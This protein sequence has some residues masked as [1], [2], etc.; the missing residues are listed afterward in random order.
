LERR[1]RF[2]VVSP[3]VLD[4]VGQE[5]LEYA[6]R[7]LALNPDTSSLDLVRLGAFYLGVD[8]VE[9][10]LELTEAGL[11]SLDA[12]PAFAANVY[13]ATGQTERA[14]EIVSVRN[15]TS[16]ISGGGADRPN[17]LIPYGGAERIRDRIR[18]LGATGVSGSELEAELAAL[19][20]VWT[21]PP[22]TEEEVLSLR[23]DVTPALATALAHDT[24]VLATWPPALELDDPIWGAVLAAWRDPT[25]ARRAIDRARFQGTEVFSVGTSAYLLGLAAAWSGDHA[26]ASV[27]FSRLLATPLA[28]SSFDPGWGLRSLSHLHRARSL[29]ELGSPDDARAAYQ[30]FVALWK[31]DDGGS[32]STYIQGLRASLFG[33]WRTLSESVS[34]LEEGGRNHG[35]LRQ[36]PKRAL[37]VRREPVVRWRRGAHSA[38]VHTFQGFDARTLQRRRSPLPGADRASAVHGKGEGPANGQSSEEAEQQEAMS[39]FP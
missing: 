35:T 30:Q 10:A 28:Y 29:L 3:E 39:V 8:S 21:V 24:V 14:L 9:R 2:G 12:P 18:V 6:L 34:S 1:A 26:L 25:T 36:V 15:Q 13:L 37:G 33:L 38:G 23:V 31:S 20:A 7:A 22:Y 16:Y 27:Q 19:E 11:A 5:I 4:S 17:G 32:S